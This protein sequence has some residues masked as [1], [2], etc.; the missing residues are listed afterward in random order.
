MGDPAMKV[1]HIFASRVARLS[2]EIV[3]DGWEY[4][5]FDKPE[6][7]LPP[8]VSVESAMMRAAHE[9][10]G[11]PGWWRKSMMK[12]N[13]CLQQIRW[14]VLEEIEFEQHSKAET[15]A[16]MRWKTLDRDE[17]ML[18]LLFAANWLRSIGL[19]KMRIKR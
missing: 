7:I 18:M 15:E 5:T 17:T 19:K 12:A 16:R 1:D 3:A 11:G 13:L 8:G 14:I 2:A 9:I 4:G 6:W 10:W